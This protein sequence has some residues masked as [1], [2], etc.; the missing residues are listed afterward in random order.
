MKEN[1]NSLISHVDLDGVSVVIVAKLLGLLE[2]EDHPTLLDYSQL[3]VDEEETISAVPTNENYSKVYYADLGISEPIYSSLTEFYG[4]ENVFFFDHHQQSLLFGDKENVYADENKCGTKI[5]YDYLKSGKRV[6]TILDNFVNIVDAYDRW[7]LDSPLREQ[8]ENLNRVLYR[9][10]KWNAKNNYLKARPFID[11]QIKKFLSQT[12]TK[13]REFFFTDYEKYQI[14][15]A[16]EK[17]EREYQYALENVKK[18]E[19]SQGREFLI[20]HGSSKISY[21][22]NRMLKENPHSQYVVAVNTF[23]GNPRVREITGR[24]SVRSREDEF[25]CTHLKGVE[26]HIAAAGGMLNPQFVHDLYNK[27]DYELG[28]KNETI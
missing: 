18:R 20:F 23:T 12:G 7:L 16:I 27:D 13:A 24:I 5:F 25:D 17:E 2:M 11:Y 28:Y 21:I 15:L 8:S 1:K 10:V 26:G 6:P 19:D 14:Q 22:C 9:M 3:Y 4:K